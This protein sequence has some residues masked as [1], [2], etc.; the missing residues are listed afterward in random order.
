[1]IY[2][3]VD[4]G[5]HKHAVAGIRDTGEVVSS[6]RFVTQNAGGFAALLGLLT[7]LGGPKAVRICMEATGPYWKVVRHQL[8]Q[9]EYSVAVINPLLAAREASADIRGRKTDKLDAI[10]IAQVVRRG[11]F[12]S[13]P[14]EEADTDALKV[15]VRQ[16]KYLIERRSEVKQRLGASLDVV[17]AEAATALGD[18]YNLSSREVLRTFPSARLLATADIRKLTT[19]F[20]DASGGHLGRV[21]AERVRQAARQSVSSTL[22]N[23]AEEFIITQILEELASLDSQ[24]TQVEARILACEAPPVAGLLQSIK[25]TGKIQPLVAA[26][27]IGDLG[28]FAGPNMAARVLAYA[29]SEPR[30]RESGKWKG[31]NKM[32]KRG[33]TTLRNS[34]YL[35][36]CTVRL[37]TPYFNNI[38]KCQRAKGKHHNVAISHVMRKL[39]HVLCGM[40][41]NGTSFSPPQPQAVPC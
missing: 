27:E 3:G 1:M 25:G 41:K 11:G 19:L 32:S 6:P 26:A 15:Y 12:H 9:N 4:I 30:V 34:L 10:A 29:G 14:P 5:K 33:S 36:A 38:Y 21:D 24:I 40:Y 37:H 22:V 20:K 23:P 8:A 7:D 18:I 2:V 13:A 39:I 28:R 16:R 31:R 35:M 17:F